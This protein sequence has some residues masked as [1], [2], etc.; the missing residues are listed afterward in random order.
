MYSQPAQAG[1]AAGT[2]QLL[3]LQLAASALALVCVVAGFGSSLLVPCLLMAVSPN[4]QLSP[5]KP[6]PFVAGMGPPI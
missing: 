2:R 5:S 6:V 3:Q 1:T 4:T